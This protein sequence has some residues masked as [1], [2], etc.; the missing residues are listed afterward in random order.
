MLMK[1]LR[2]TRKGLL[3][4]VAATLLLILP[5]WLLDRG[6]QG[7][8]YSPGEAPPH[9]IAIVFGAGLRRDGRPTTVLADRIATAA[10]LYHSGKVEK[11]LLSGSARPDGYDEAASMRSF[12][13]ELGVAERDILT[14]S[15]GDRTFLTCLR[16]HEVFGIDSAV[17][18]TQRYHLPRALVLCDAMGIEA[19]GAI[20]DLRAYRAERFWTLR[21]SFATLRA[22]WDAGITQL[23]RLNRS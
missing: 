15:S 23:T 21:E 22:L 4:G 8:I 6:Y 11:I 13:L 2:S 7:R 20:S 9:P 14:D 5:R 19:D 3:L 12:A 17:L 18:V 16:A 1:T 10:Q